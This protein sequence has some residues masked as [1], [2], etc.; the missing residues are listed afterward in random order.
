MFKLFKWCFT[1]SVRALLAMTAIYGVLFLI[2]FFPIFKGL[3]LLIVLPLAV[4]AAFLTMKLWT[5]SVSKRAFKTFE[6]GHTDM[7]HDYMLL[8]YK[9]AHYTA[10][11]PAAAIR[12]VA[13]L[14]ERGEYEKALGILERYTEKKY[15]SL[16]DVTR[17]SYYNN[18]TQALLKSDR[19]AE[20]EEVYAKMTDLLGA[21]EEPVTGAMKNAFTMT[22]AELR[23]MQGDTEKAFELIDTLEDTGTPRRVMQ[24]RLLRGKILLALEKPEEAAKE[25]TFV[26]ENGKEETKR[27]A[28]RLM[29]V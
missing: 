21:Y 20:A 25:F 3:W 14:L 9:K 18:R 26:I 17:L 7:L 2:P 24:R 22:E 10:E 5:K 4:L 12:Y 19:L 13:V 15:E 16:D 8:L 28:E 27:T 1:N 11:G 29:Q 6:E 23:L